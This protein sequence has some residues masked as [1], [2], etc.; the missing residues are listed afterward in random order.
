MVVIA[1]SAPPTVVI[2][3]V[4]TA[5]V[6]PIVIAASAPPTVIAVIVTFVPVVA[7]PPVVV[8]LVAHAHADLAVLELGVEVDLA[9]AHGEV[10]LDLAALRLV[11]VGRPTIGGGEG[12]D[13]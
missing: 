8:D 9:R 10:H 4:V 13:A 3:V 2:P 5:I 1:A 11:D 6:V 12:D 7:A